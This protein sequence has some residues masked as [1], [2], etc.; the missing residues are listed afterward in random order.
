MPNIKDWIPGEHIQAVIYG[1]SG[2]G[3]TDLAGQFPRPRFLDFDRGIATLR[4]P[5]FVARHGVAD[6]DYIQPIE[7]GLNERGVPKT[8]NAFDDACMYFDKSMKDD[9]DK[10][11]TW[12]LDTCTT[13]AQAARNKGVILLGTVDFKQMSKTH[14]QAI[15]TG[16]LVPKQADY[17]SER[18]LVEQFIRMLKD[19]GKNVIILAHEK[20]IS[21]EGGTVVAR[22]PLLTGQSSEVVSGMFDEV[23]RLTMTGVGNQRKRV[24]KTETDTVSMAK[25]RYGLPDGMEA[26]YKAIRAHLD[27]LIHTGNVTT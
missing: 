19:S 6:I 25:T 15:R 4:N 13:L 22:V 5:S 27:S 9:V 16:L 23:W 14:S 18:S 10:F 1:K 12:V 26:S 17:G 2:V 8:H 3:K 7:R 20:E 21:D 24:L 11:D